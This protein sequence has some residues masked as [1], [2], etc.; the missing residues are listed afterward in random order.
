MRLISHGFCHLTNDTNIVNYIYSFNGTIPRWWPS[1]LL[2]IY[3]VMNGCWVLNDMSCIRR[4]ITYM[5]GCVC[6]RVRICHPVCRHVVMKSCFPIVL[7][8]SVISYILIQCSERHRNFPQLS[9]TYKTWLF[10]YFSKRSYVFTILITSAD[11]HCHSTFIAS[12][13]NRIITSS[14]FKY[15]SGLFVNIYLQKT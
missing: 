13:I 3:F 7:L 6:F 15:N 4:Y 2:C 1:F 5:W 10:G 9:R 8:A 14:R 11:K 12:A